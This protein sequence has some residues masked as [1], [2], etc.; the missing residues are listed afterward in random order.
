[1]LVNLANK[2][3]LIQTDNIPF[4]MK[5]LSIIPKNKHHD[6]AISYFDGKELHYLKSERIEQIKHHHIKTK[7]DYENYFEAIG[8]APPVINQTKDRGN[9]SAILQRWVVSRAITDC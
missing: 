2:Y 7:K 3:I 5:F 1:M 9:H 4:I 8:E 6:S